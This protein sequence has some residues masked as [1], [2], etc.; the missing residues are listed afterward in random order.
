MFSAAHTQYCRTRCV[1]HRTFVKYVYIQ[2]LL[3]MFHSVTHVQGMTLN[4]IH[5]FIVTGSFLYW[6]VIKVVSLRFFIQSRIYLRIFS[7]SYLATFLGTSQ[8]VLMCRKAVNQSMSHALSLST[9]TI[10]Q[11]HKITTS[12]P[13]IQISCTYI[14]MISNDFQIDC[15][16][17]LRI[18][19]NINH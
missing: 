16:D 6:C 8:S 1:L 2:H 9:P 4:C 14:N 3:V 5:I 7:I 13:Y 12:T 11:Y 10:S 17:G 15:N 18:L 19:I